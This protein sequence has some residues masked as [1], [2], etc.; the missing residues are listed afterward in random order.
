MKFNPIKKIKITSVAAKA[1][2]TNGLF[3][4]G[5]YGSDCKDECCEYGCD[6]DVASLKL[7][8]KNRALIEPL[9]KAKIEDCFST[10]L[11]KDDDY[12]GGGYRESKV[13]KADS[14]C[15][16]HLHDQRGCSLFYVWGKLGVSK[17]IVPT[18]CRTYPITWH[19]G[20]LFVDEPLRKSCKCM[21]KTPTGVKVP[22]LMETQ[23]KEIRILFDMQLKK[24][25]A[26]K[27]T[28]KK[29]A[30]KKTIKKKTTAKKAATKKTA[31]KKKPTKKK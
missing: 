22:S 31:T 6:V 5:C 27:A 10:P 13:R 4:E 19:R 25:P 3:D 29:A 9:I 21:D 7:I 12:V 11:K 24:A 2:S 8:E 20:R 30:A 26:K 14:V 18:I 28:V 17:R 23:A 16:F 1:Y 15:S